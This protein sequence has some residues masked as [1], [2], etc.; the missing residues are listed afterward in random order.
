M[1]LARDH[2]YYH[3]AGMSVSPDNKWLA[4]GEDTVSRRLYTLRLKNLE[5]QEITDLQME[6]TTGGSAWSSDNQTLFFTERDPE[7]LRAHKIISLDLKTGETRL[8]Y[9]ELDDTFYCHVYKTQIQGVPY[10]LMWQHPD[11]G[12][13]TFSAQTTPKESL[14]FFRR[15]YGEW[16]T[17]VTHYNG[18]WYNHHQLGGSEFPIDENRS[19]PD[20]TGVLAGNDRP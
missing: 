14:R 19:Q 3:V 10:D 16:S 5:T 12:S 13:T 15:G 2:A 6:N 4:F 11:H 17:G 1:N 20:K 7:T 18:L 8:R 9:E